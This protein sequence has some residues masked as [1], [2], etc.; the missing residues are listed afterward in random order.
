M[1]LPTTFSFPSDTLNP[2]DIP[3]LLIVSGL[4]YLAWCPQRTSMLKYGKTSL[5][6]KV[7][8]YSTVWLQLIISVPWSFKLPLWFQRW[9]IQFSPWKNRKGET[10]LCWFICFLVNHQKPPEVR[11]LTWQ[12]VHSNL[13]DT[14]NRRKFWECWEQ[15]QGK[16]KVQ[17]R[18][19]SLAAKLKYLTIRKYMY[20]EFLLYKN[21]FMYACM[22]LRGR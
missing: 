17:A 15:N 14:D 3:H 19:W 9:I 4:F 1:L 11:L 7:G 22:Y 16:V 18:R 20:T 13:N 2:L 12:Q 10:H 6:L 5:F 21:V 8:Y